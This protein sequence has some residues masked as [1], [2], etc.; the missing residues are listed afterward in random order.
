VGC[1]GVGLTAGRH[2]N[3]DGLD[4]GPHCRVSEEGR[5]ILG[6]RRGAPVGIFVAPVDVAV[7]VEDRRV[8]L[9]QMQV[10]IRGFGPA[11]LNPEFLLAGARVHDKLVSHGAFM[12]LVVCDHQREGKVARKVRRKEGGCGCGVAEFGA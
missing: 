1:N 3:A 4:T 5:V 7:R 2:L 12:A 8:G 6:L 9:E 11:D 10:D